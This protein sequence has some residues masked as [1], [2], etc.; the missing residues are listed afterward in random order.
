[1]SDDETRLGQHYHVLM[2]LAKSKAW[3][4]GDLDA[5][6]REVT[7]AAA[8]T[9]GVERVN[10][11][12]FDERRSQI[13]CIE[14]YERT[15]G[16]HSSG[17]EIHAADCPGYF[18]ALEEER[19]IVAHDAHADPRTCEF[20]G[21][22]LD[23]HGITSLL[24]APIHAG[25]EVIGI[26][27]H[28]HIGPARIWT[29]EEQSFAASLADLAAL[30][31][32]SAQRRD[33]EA[34]RRC[35]EQR[36]RAL[37]DH[38]L[39]PIVTTD[40]HGTVTDWNPSAE[41]VFGWTRRE[42]IGRPLV[43]T[44]F[45]D[46]DRGEL[47]AAMSAWSTGRENAILDRRIERT[48]IDAGGRRF[49]VELSVS[50]VRIGDETMF[51]VFVRDITKRRRAERELRDL[52]TALEER[53]LD[54]TT[55]LRSAVLERERLLDELRQ[56]SREL[57][58]RLIEVER[59]TE[60]IRND[61]ERA[62]VIQRALLPTEPPRLEG[63]HV[64]AL[65]RPGMIVGGD[66]YDVVSLDDR[67]LAL[68]VADAAGHGVAAAM[69]S[70]LFKQRLEL[71]DAPGPV[72]PAEVL[73]RVNERLLKDRVLARGLFLTVAIALVD[74]ETGDLRLASAGHTATLIRRSDGSTRLLGH[75]GPA[76][77][78]EENAR[79]SEH[80]I[81]LERGDR[82]VL[83]TDGLTEGIEDLDDLRLTEFLAPALIGD[84]RDGPYRLRGLFQ[85]ATRRADRHDSGGDRDDVTLLVLDRS[86]GV[87]HLDHSPGPIERE[88]EPSPESSSDEAAILWIARGSAETYLAVRGRGLWRACD[89]FLRLAREALVAGRRVTVD[90]S[91][92]TF[93]D[94]AFLGTLHELV[95]DGSG[96]EVVLRG[97]SATVRASVDELELTRVASAIAEGAARPPVEPS[98]VIDEA[99]GFASRMR[100][101]RAHTVLSELSP[102]NHERFSGVV[103]ALREE[104]GSD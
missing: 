78:L 81:T 82:A 59:K 95:S 52:N 8:H 38:A 25:G 13:R 37:V 73:S 6:L 44:I 2:R 64:A 32:E 39:D 93:L 21:G 68:Y 87:S 11:W 43:E 47:H 98:P 28:E 34:A 72:A 104:L 61:L 96:G 42:A 77:G 46:G 74:L 12:L 20:S 33:A 70:V 76:I 35:S 7:E 79:F 88:E 48:A 9:L 10:I 80:R 66:L 65:Y 86:V 97:P 16:V 18:R 49:P 26:V 53:V 14:H 69:L 15:H 40:A 27:C 71:R 24:D 103:D 90:L 22:Y 3:G 41:A 60:I 54:R 100:L 85:D 89:T 63:A 30:A 45:P 51:S 92:C 29:T 50:P 1:M 55:Q 102:E 23:Q 84:A 91:E 57:L 99:P 56:S 5:A 19:A 31:I 17:A 94:S 101:L 62:Q 58:Q 75:T 83:Y 36:T 67:W 4:Q